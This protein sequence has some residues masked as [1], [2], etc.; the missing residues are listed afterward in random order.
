MKPIDP[1]IMK[2]F[3]EFK[4]LQISSELGDIL[5]LR[6]DDPSITLEFRHKLAQTLGNRLGVPIIFIKDTM[7]V[8]LSTIDNVRKL[9][10]KME[11]KIKELRPSSELH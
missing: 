4:A 1:E 11:S 2:S 8:E 7:E 9:L 5:V 6:D 3:S 10:D